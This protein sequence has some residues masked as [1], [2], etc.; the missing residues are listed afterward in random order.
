MSGELIQTKLYVPQLQP[1]F[2]H[3]PRLIKRID[4]G[5]QNVSKLTLV[6]APA[7]FGKSSLITD[8]G[9]R[10]AESLTAKSSI[11]YSK[12]CWLSLDPYDDDPNRFWQYLVAALR[13]A[14]P[15]LGASTQQMLSS[16]PLPPPPALLT[17]LLNE[18]AILEELIILVL[19]D[20][21]LIT[22]AAV[23]EGL[24]FVLDHAPP[25]LHLILITRADPPL[26]LTRL[27]A[28]LASGALPPLAWTLQDWLTRTLQGLTAGY[29]D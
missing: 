27:R 20:Y 17:G 1:F 23:H 15:H 10:M 26:A 2:I 9:R 5:L 13:T 4:Q 8:W 18:V 3:R 11:P 25:R 24:Q 7:G 21:H 6:S 29:L 19:D 14:V 12:L 22:D 16:T 28:D